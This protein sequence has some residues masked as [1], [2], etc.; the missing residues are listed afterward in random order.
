M[1]HNFVVLLSQLLE[2][3]AIPIPCGVLLVKVGV[4]ERNQLQLNFGPRYLHEL[5]TAF[6]VPLEYPLNEIS[7]G[8]LLAQHFFAQS[9]L[10]VL[11]VLSLALELT[12][13]PPHG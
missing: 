4:Y 9:G 3:L 1:L 12:Q 7:I 8:I 10:L 6:V 2:S 11:L 13:F 5:P